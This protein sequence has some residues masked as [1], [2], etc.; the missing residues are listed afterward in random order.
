MKLQKIL[1]KIVI[2]FGCALGNAGKI[3]NVI[4]KNLSDNS[5]LLRTSQQ[6]SNAC[7]NSFQSND[8]VLSSGTTLRMQLDSIQSPPRDPFTVGRSFSMKDDLASRLRSIARD[9]GEQNDIRDLVRSTPL[10]Q[11]LAK[12][13]PSFSSVE[14]FQREGALV[15]LR[16]AIARDSE[17]KE[18][19]VNEIL[20]AY[21]LLNAVYKWRSIPH[22]HGYY[23]HYTDAADMLLSL[24]ITKQE[25]ERTPE[26]MAKIRQ[27]ISEREIERRSGY[28]SA[29]A[30]EDIIEML[31]SL[32]MANGPVLLRKDGLSYLIPRVLKN[33]EI[34]VTRGGSRRLPVEYFAEV[35]LSIDPELLTEEF[36]ELRDNALKVFAGVYLRRPEVTDGQEINKFFASVPGL[37][38]R[39]Q[40]IIRSMRGR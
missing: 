40:Q 11:M 16:F 10:S 24:A 30:R 35:F 6:T 20:K 31:R 34:K 9:L 27:A 29:E 1:A 39:L 26:G 25:S 33:I 32:R 15:F 37:T 22:F 13:N 28:L 17:I 2:T 38:E 3:D 19:T 7:A 4:Q 14:N 36:S 18:L 21:F 5:H 23:G 12:V 8:T